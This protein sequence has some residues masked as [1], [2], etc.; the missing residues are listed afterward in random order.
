[1]PYS[2]GVGTVIALAVGVIAVVLLVAHGF[3]WPL[4]LIA[5]LAAARLT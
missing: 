3:T 1:M 2:I 4:L 5:L